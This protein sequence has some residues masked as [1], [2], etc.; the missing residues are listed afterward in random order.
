MLNDTF[1]A[2][3]TVIESSDDHDVN[4]AELLLHSIILIQVNIYCNEII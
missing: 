3:E 2:D 1:A 4:T